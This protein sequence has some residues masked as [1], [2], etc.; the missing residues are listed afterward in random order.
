[1]PYS[2]LFTLL[3]THTIGIIF[4]IFIGRYFKKKNDALWQEKYDAIHA[5]YT[6]LNKVY[7]KEKKQI[8]RLEQDRDSWKYKYQTLNTEHNTL[9]EEHS[10]SKATIVEK[11]STCDTLTTELERLKNR[12]QNLEKEHEKLKK[13]IFIQVVI[14]PL[15]LIELC[16]TQRLLEN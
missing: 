13:K 8:N 14:I 5:E 3:L 1:M 12:H 11:Q 9:N 4:G 15:F 16:I 6:D 10:T 7:K 2:E